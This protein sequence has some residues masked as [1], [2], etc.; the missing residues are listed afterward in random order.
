[1]LFFTNFLAV[2]QKAP[3]VREVKETIYMIGVTTLI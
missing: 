1:M 3:V 2:F